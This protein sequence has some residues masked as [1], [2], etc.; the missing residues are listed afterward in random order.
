MPKSL[1]RRG[2][3]STTNSPYTSPFTSPTDE[4]EDPFRRTSSP[5]PVA[6]VPFETG[7]S[8]G[9]GTDARRAVRV[10]AARASAAARKATIAKKLAVVKG[11][12]YGSSPSTAVSD[13]ESSPNSASSSALE[14]QTKEEEARPKVAIS[15]LPQPDSSNLTSNLQEIEISRVYPTT[16]W[17]PKMPEV[18]QYFLRLFVPTITPAHSTGREDIRAHLWPQAQ[19]DAALFHALLLLAASHA[20][21]SRALNL[22]PELISQ[23]KYTTLESINTAI[24]GSSQDGRMQDPVITAIALLGGWELEYGDPVMYDTHMGGLTGIVN[25]VRGGLS[26]I[27]IPNG[28]PPLPPISRNIILGSGHDS[29][30]YAG[31]TPFFD[32][33]AGNPRMGMPV[34]PSTFP[35]GLEELRAQRLV[36][37]N[38]LHLLYRLSYIVP[39]D[40]SSHS[41]LVD[42]EQILS[43]W[44]YGKITAARFDISQTIFEDDLKWQIHTFIRLAGLGLCGFFHLANGAPSYEPLHQWYEESQVLQADLFLGTVFEEVLFWALFT[45]C[46]TSGHSEAHHMRTLKRLKV[47]L[48][49]PSWAGLTELM[50][51]YVYPSQILGNRA[52]AL[53]TAISLSSISEYQREV[54]E[55]T[56]YVKGSRHPMN[57]VGAGAPPVQAGK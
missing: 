11:E 49:I 41:R 6:F 26:G 45:L 39:R 16:K 46:A 32:H 43:E 15:R 14:R 23:L 22:S 53:W 8:G 27:Q 12:R 51:K 35:I 17:H 48:G 1:S 24:G 13:D 21:V 47:A 36:L 18:V 55:P 19:N 3:R 50:G 2:N 31:R 57:W 4:K 54:R 40:T 29:A 9:V 25:T 56:R 5:G 34:L 38:V 10:Q 28:P 44:E 20:V 42:T 7:I 52:F 30:L 37:P 33:P